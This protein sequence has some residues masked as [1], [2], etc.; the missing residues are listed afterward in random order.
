[1]VTGL[2]DIVK[3]LNKAKDVGATALFTAAVFI[4]AEA[5]KITPVHYNNLLPS[6]YVQM[7]ERSS[8]KDLLTAEVG[9]T[10]SYA[11]Y[12]HEMPSDTH[13]RKPTAEN[14]FLERALMENETKVQEILGASLTRFE[15]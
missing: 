4:K 12:V 1:M 10:V 9:Y 3:D 7:E 11:P 2:D 5:Q 14:K 15:K 13:W 6:C 8:N